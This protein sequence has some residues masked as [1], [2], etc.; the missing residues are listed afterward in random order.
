M[1]IKYVGETPRYTVHLPPPRQNIS[2]GF[3]KGH[4]VVEIRD[5][6]HGKA[7][8]FTDYPD[9]ENRNK[10]VEEVTGLF[11]GDAPVKHTAVSPEPSRAALAEAGVE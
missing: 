6:E 10:N 9:C 2:Y 1:K 4:P 11:S 5:D 7:I 3:Q 8:L